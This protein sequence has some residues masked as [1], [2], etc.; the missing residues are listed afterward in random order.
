LA[1]VAL[2]V[3]GAVAAASA[4][5][6]GGSADHAAARAL[7]QLRSTALGRVL[8]DRRGRTLYL[9]EA[10]RG[11]TSV[12]YGKCATVWPPLLTSGKPRA[13]VGARAAL[14]GTTKRRNGRLQVTYRGHPLYFFVG[15]ERSGQTLGQG[16][17]GFGGEWYVLD[18]AGR[19]IE[20][21]PASSGGETTTTTT[22]TTTETTTD[23]GG[24][25]YGG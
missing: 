2:L 5:A 1:L 8:V 19:K 15:D 25:G 17:D 23:D 11:T 12:C 14:L 18:R 16:I 4:F 22:P 24:Y 7:V 13:G 21:R 3:L 10:D 6:F 9:F 20:K